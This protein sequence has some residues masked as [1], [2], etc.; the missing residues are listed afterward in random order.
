M[1]HKDERTNFNTEEA[2]QDLTNILTP[3]TH[4]PLSVSVLW[5]PRVLRD[6]PKDNLYLYKSDT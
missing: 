1:D 3:S 5:T 2:V 6:T 4:N